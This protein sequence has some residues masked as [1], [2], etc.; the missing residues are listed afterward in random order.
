M[1]KFILEEWKKPT[2]FELFRTPKM[3]LKGCGASASSLTATSS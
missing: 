3:T 2:F 1:F